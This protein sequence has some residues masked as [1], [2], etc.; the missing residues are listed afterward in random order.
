MKRL[1]GALILL[2]C[3]CAPADAPETRV[4]AVLV[5]LEAAVQARDVGALKDALSPDYKDAQ[6]NDRR[7]VLALATAHF[8]RNQSVYVLSRIRSLE[9]P[10]PRFARA[11]AL[12][13]LAGVPIRDA[14]SL[15]GLNADLYRFD[16]RLREESGEWRIVSAAWQPATA[17]DFE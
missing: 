5:G 1:L 10:E 12:V 14:L 9:I 2:A 13:A 6:G 17:G 4:R 11:D 15:P 7:A 16:V 8:M 3:A